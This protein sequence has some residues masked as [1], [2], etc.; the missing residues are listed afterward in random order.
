MTRFDMCGKGLFV[1]INRNCGGLFDLCEQL[2]KKDS[3]IHVIRA[4]HSERMAK[5]YAKKNSLPIVKEG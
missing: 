5:S 3:D 2:G 4:F 1:L